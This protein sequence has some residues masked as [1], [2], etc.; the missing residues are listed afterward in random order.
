MQPMEEARLRAVDEGMD[1]VDRLIR[2]YR[3]ELAPNYF[4]VVRAGWLRIGVGSAAARKVLIRVQGQT[5]DPDDDELIE[6]KEVANLDGLQCLEDSATAQAARVIVGT[7]QLGRLKHD[8][9]AVGPTLL[10]P[11]V[12]DRAEH[13]LDWWVSSWEPSYREVRLSDLRSASDLGDIAFDAGLQLGAGKLGEL[14]PQVLA[15]AAELETRMRKETAI[16][17]EELLEGWRE[18]GG[19]ALASS[20]L[21]AN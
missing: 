10:I 19:R 5:A 21:N 4:K 2:A 18:L 12:A 16:L 7:R 9:L 20:E 6:A 15:S 3:P 14:K 17:V 1:G 11:T 8:I 13:W